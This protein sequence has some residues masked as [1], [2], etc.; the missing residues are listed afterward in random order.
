MSD[1][2][3]GG[4]DL[5]VAPDTKAYDQREPIRG[6]IVFDNG[7]TQRISHARYS[8]GV[9]LKVDHVVIDGMPYTR[10]DNLKKQDSQC[11]F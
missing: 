3:H 4:R 8:N 7:S 9:E 6:L 2:R 11:K 5:Y 1:C 10:D